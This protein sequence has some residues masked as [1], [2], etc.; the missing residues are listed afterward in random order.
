VTELRCER[1]GEAFGC[2]AGSG[3]CWCAEV[4]VGDATRAMLALTYERCLCPACLAA[5]E[6]EVSRRPG[7]TRARS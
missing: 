6:R 3:S 5:A 2:G 7:P 4:E 1:C